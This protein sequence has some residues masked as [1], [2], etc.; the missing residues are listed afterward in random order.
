MKLTV[1]SVQPGLVRINS[2]DDITILDF[3]D[4]AQ[5]LEALLSPEAYQGTV[6][7]NL[8]E[9]SY[10][11]SSGVGWLVQCHGHFQKAG[12]R[13]V[14][15]SISPMVNHCFRVL[16]MYDLLNIAPDEPAA[17]KLAT[18]LVSSPLPACG[19]GGRG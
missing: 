2:A 13:L 4:G 1:V 11:D 5:P 14:L 10:I 17:L 15:H 6:L 16:G 19:E 7:L 9:S 18:L 8:A 3:A 12:G